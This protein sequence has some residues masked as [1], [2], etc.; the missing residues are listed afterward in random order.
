MKAFFWKEKEEE[1]RPIDNQQKKAGSIPN[2][3]GGNTILRVEGR[4]LFASRGYRILR[5]S[6]FGKS[7]QEDGRLPV[8]WWRKLSGVS[9]WLGR[10]TRGGVFHVL[11]QGDGARIGIGPK[12]IARA[13]PDSSEYRRVFRFPRGFRP[14][15]LCQAPGGKIYWG[16]YFLNFRR[17]ESV[18]IF[19]SDDGGRTWRSV[20][21]F[22]PGAV[23]HVHRIVH[24]PHGD[25]L[26]VCTGD[27]DRESAI[28]QTSDEFQTLV[29]LVQ[30]SQRFRTTCLIPQRDFLVYGTDNPRGKNF[31]MALD[32]K[33]GKAEEIQELPGPALY[34]TRV[35]EWLAFSTMVE[36]SSH[37]VTIWAGK[38]TS[39][40][41]VAFFETL[42]GNQAWR[43]IVGY[44]R[45]ILPEGKASWPWLYCTPV[46]TRDYGDQLIRIN[47]EKTG[48]LLELMV[49]PP[50]F[51]AT[52]R[53]REKGFEEEAHP[54]IRW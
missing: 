7:W 5:S 22:P 34:G 38:G 43:E 39:F 29:P 51:P 10:V 12:L 44:S 50:F 49:H 17:S 42:K 15:N 21:T 20:F 18:R 6:D 3:Q 30:G 48:D 11:P 33:S 46:G 27:R 14:L 47:L 13:E 53:E 19:E 9:P 35:G 54:Q 24:D 4:T 26:L 32:R 31:I 52:D 25:A 2:L 36:K 40:A 37:E 45:V 16:E 41:R 23:C 1:G 28:W 8:S